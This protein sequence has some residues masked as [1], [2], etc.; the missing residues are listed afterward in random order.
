MADRQDEFKPKN[1][2]DPTKP[3]Q[4]RKKKKDKRKDQFD[5]RGKY[6]SRGER[7]KIT[8]TLEGTQTG[9]QEGN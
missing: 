4:L 2:K 7:Q 3:G 9:T 5:L 6:S 8:N 1:N